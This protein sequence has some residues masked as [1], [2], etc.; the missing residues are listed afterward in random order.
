M[1]IK[2]GVVGAGQFAQEFFPLFRAHPQ[3][4]RVYVTDM[5][6][7]RSEKAAAR[8]GLDQTYDTFEATALNFRDFC[9]WMSDSRLCVTGL[10]RCRL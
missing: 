5:I 1:G 2:M 4:Q 10:S 8:F 9:S 3:V 7:A 6:T